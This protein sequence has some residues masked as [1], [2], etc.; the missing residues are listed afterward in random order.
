MLR[1]RLDRLEGLV[2]PSP[3]PV[4]EQL[5]LMERGPLHGES[6]RA[7]WKRAGDQLAVDSDRGRSTGVTGVEVRL[8][9]RAFVPVHPDRDAV[10]EADPRHIPRPEAPDDDVE[11]A[12]VARIERELGGERSGTASISA[13]VKLCRGLADVD[14]VGKRGEIYRVPRE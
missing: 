10:E 2:S 11:V 12:R 1:Q 7:W 13:G 4:G 3:L 9:V 14:E 8:S 5:I 6:E